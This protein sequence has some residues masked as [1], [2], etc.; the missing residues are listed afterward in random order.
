MEQFPLSDDGSLA[1]VNNPHGTPVFWDTEGQDSGLRLERRRLL[2]WTDDEADTYVKIP[3]GDV[4]GFVLKADL[5]IWTPLDPPQ[6][7]E[8]QEV[9]ID[10]DVGTQMLAVMQGETIQYLTL[11]STAKKG[12]TTPLGTYQIY[13]KSVGWDLGSRENSD[14]PY[15]MERVPFVMHYYPRYAIHSAFWHDNFGEPASHGCINL[16]PKDALE[17]YRRVSPSM[18]AG[19]QYVKQHDDDPGTVLRI[20]NGD[21][22]GRTKRIRP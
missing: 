17:V 13:D 19:W 1:W 6:G 8:A 12:H 2:E 14:D 18:P 21:T 4:D 9:W 22:T 7:I 11:M 5:T 3:M 16:A 20:R 10:A 15:Y